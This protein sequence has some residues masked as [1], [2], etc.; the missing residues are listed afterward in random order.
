VPDVVVEH[1]KALKEWIGLLGYSC[2]DGIQ[3]SNTGPSG[4]GGTQ[5]TTINSRVIAF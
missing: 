4:Q 3:V 2:I 5:C 1:G